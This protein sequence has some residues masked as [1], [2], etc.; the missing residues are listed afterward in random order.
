MHGQHG[1]A[2]FNRLDEFSARP[3]HVPHAVT[4]FAADKIAYLSVNRG[5]V[6]D[7]EPTFRL[8]RRGNRAEGEI[9]GKENSVHAFP[10]IHEDAAVVV[11]SVLGAER[12][13]QRFRSDFVRDFI[14]VM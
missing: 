6:S 8:D 7:D 13:A 1:D 12:V 10:R 9:E 4:A 11:H 2:V 3:E 14:Y 5:M